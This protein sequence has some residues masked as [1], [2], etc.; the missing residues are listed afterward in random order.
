MGFCMG[1]RRAVDMAAAE[2]SKTTCVYTLG[3]LIH[4]GEALAALEKCGVKEITHLPDDAEN[5]SVV[6]RAHGINP[7]AEYGLR[8]KRVNIIDATCPNVKSLQIKA[9]TL[10]KEG[11]K[12]FIAGDAEHAEIEGILGYVNAESSASFCKVVSSSF[13]AEASA[14]MLYEADKDA[15]TALI[16]QTTFSGAEYCNIGNAVKKYFPSLEVVQTICTA[17]VERQQALRNMLEKVEA[18]L[19]VGG[20]ESANTRRLLAIAQES[21][22]PCALVEKTSEIPSNFYTF[23]T[24]GISAGASTPD[25]V[26]NAIEL[27]ILR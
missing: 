25:S 22:K 2:A 12:L 15:K 13:E 18:V 19:I 21:G 17:A 1:V 3:P 6:I 27:E 26:I 8:N 10:S 14:K 7:K 23:K 9:G 11:Y 16:G 24:V 5:I 20:R 4:N